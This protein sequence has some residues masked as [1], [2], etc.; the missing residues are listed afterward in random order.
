MTQ[1]LGVGHS[2]LFSMEQ[3]YTDEPFYVYGRAHDLERLAKSRA[4]SLWLG[5]FDLTLPVELAPQEPLNVKWV[6]W[7]W[8]RYEYDT[9]ATSYK[10]STQWIVHDRIVL[11]QLIL[12]NATN[13]DLEVQFSFTSD[14]LIRDLDYLDGSYRFN[15]DDDKGYSYISGPN[16]FGH[17]CVHRLDLHNE[18]D[19][20]VKNQMSRDTPAS[21]LSSAPGDISRGPSRD[22]DCT[23]AA[24]HNGPPPDSST[25]PLAHSQSAQ[26]ETQT[27]EQTVGPLMDAQSN[28]PVPTEQAEGKAEDSQETAT[29]TN[30]SHAVACVRTLFVN[31][32]AIMTRGSSGSHT[33][34]LAGKGPESTDLYGAPSELVVA[35]KMIL[36]PK[37]P[38]HWNNFLVSAHEAD[39]NTILRDEMRRLWGAS[40]T[41]SLFSLGF[42]LGDD[43]PDLQAERSKVSKTWGTKNS[44]N[45]QKAQE[46]R[47]NEANIDF[48][49]SNEHATTM[50][51]YGNPRPAQEVEISSLAKRET[52]K[53]PV[54][55]PNK[56]SPKDHV[57]YLLWRHLEHI[58]SVCA[59]PLSAPA[60][61]KEA[62][63]S[64]SD[65]PGSPRLVAKGMPVALTCG[66]M[67][68]HRICTSASL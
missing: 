36:L 46:Q 68:G 48:E 53:S 10:S 14:G 28:L 24:R 67:A 61:F 62:G 31:G 65:P 52:T 13:E 16:G 30:D 7:R 57:E 39:V 38:I 42:S 63:K 45:N 17:I 35:Y 5:A 40:E 34:T 1:Y 44:P 2:G 33:F 66:D 37:G 25:P 32:K 4:D 54:G 27:I 50:M 64:S 43:T 59:V 19:D 58:L 11:K 56:T 41:A 8:P 22:I 21:S 12:E 26:H 23:T 29:H 60:L 55:T 20:S 6:N 9:G 15:D 47:E 51:G 3:R 49:A 18:A